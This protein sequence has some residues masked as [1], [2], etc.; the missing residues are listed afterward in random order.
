MRIPKLMKSLAVAFLSICGLS[1]LAQTGATISFPEHYRMW[2]HV[3]TTVIGS[4]SPNFARNGGMHLFY[5]NEV[6]VEGY[7]SGKFPDGAVLV[8]DLLDAKEVDGVTRGG[9]RRRVAVMVKDSARFPETG[10]WGFEV[11]MSEEKS[12]G[13]LTSEGRAACFAC[14]RNGRDAVFSELH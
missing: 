10:G 14:H 5:A 6:A 2:V 8:D 4:N 3:K 1:V 13:S 7:R 12:K 11:F 9:S